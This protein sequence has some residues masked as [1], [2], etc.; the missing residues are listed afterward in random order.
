VPE[1]Y[2]DITLPSGEPM[3]CYS[4]SLIVTELLSAG[5]RYPVF[6]FRAR[7]RAALEIASERVRLKYGFSCSAALDQLGVL[8][9]ELAKLPVEAQIVVQGFT[10]A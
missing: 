7:A 4:P 10:P 3:R 8:E 1:V 5:A 2:F 9:R 6:E